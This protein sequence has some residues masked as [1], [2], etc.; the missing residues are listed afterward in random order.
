MDDSGRLEH[1]VH[2]DPVASPA[3]RS[4]DFHTV[5]PSAKKVLEAALALP[6]EAREELV[7]ALSISLEPTSSTPECQSEIARRL[8]KIENGEATFY[9]AENH[10]RTLRAKVRG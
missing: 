4:Y 2:L 1:P 7:A 10:L 6:A 3:S 8:E 5:A 9:D